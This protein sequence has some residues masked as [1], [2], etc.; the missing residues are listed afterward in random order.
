MNK[1][2]LRLSLIGIAGVGLAVTLALANTPARNVSSV[3]HPN[4][5][6][7]QRLCEEAYQ[8]ITAAQ[9]ANEFDMHG[10]AAKAKALL[11]E[12]NAEIKLAA[13]A[14]NENAPR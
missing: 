13:E 6:A 5:A 3:R 10:H 9:E 1:S 11:G 4:L 8:K 7:A 12:A 2:I 14:A